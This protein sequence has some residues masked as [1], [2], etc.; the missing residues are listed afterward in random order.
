MLVWVQLNENSKNVLPNFTTLIDLKDE[1]KEGK[2]VYDFTKL[3]AEL[4]KLSSDIKS[5]EVYYNKQT[6]LLENLPNK[7]QEN[8]L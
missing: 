3:K 4:D 1:K 2:Y 8:D 5:V 7:T 6:I